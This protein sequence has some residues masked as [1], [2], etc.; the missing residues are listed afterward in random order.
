MRY[1]RGLGLCLFFVHSVPALAQNYAANTY[2]RTNPKFI[3][4]FKE[5]VAKPSS[6]TVRVLCDG[7]DTAL[8]MVVGPD[9]WILTK[10]NDLRGKITCK[11]RDGRLF[12]AA[13]VGVQKDHDLAMLKVEARGLTPVEFSDSKAAEVGHW[14]ACAGLGDDP[15]G[16]GVVSVATRQM[17]NK[18]PTVTIDATKAGYLG[19][20]LDATEGG[21]KI[22][23]VA[24]GTAAATAGIKVND[25]VT[26]LAG[27]KITEVDEFIDKVGK[28]K[29]GD[30]VVM[31]LLRGKEELELKATLGK[32]PANMLRGDF[33][34]KMGSELSARRTGYPTILQH[35]SVV[36]PTDCGGPIVDLEGRVIGI[37]ICRAGRTESWAVPAEVIQTVLL[38]L[39]SGKL[40]PPETKLTSLTSE[41]RIAAAKEAVKR[42]E[43]EKARAEKRLAEARAALEALQAAQDQDKKTDAPM[44]SVDPMRPTN[45]STPPD[46]L[47][48]QPS[49]IVERPMTKE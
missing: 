1:L 35:D 4:A 36:K 32:R 6:S 8:G 28:Y 14:V 25:I 44:R 34:N 46:N 16:I 39:M 23:M 21:V 33:Q 19:V 27:Q 7:K 20:S 38:E 45:Q 9:G 10:S 40:A 5:V 24:P 43:E 47:S 22:V 17:L 41:E 2:T 42:A 37:N 15:V 30:V 48:S 31:K 11:L 18:G 12:E 29:P 26:T 13:L 3:Q 49:A